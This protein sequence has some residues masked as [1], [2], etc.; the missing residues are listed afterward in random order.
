MSVKVHSVTIDAKGDTWLILQKPKDKSLQPSSRHEV[1]FEVCSSTLSEASTSWKSA[2]ETS[3]A[4]VDGSLHVFTSNL[5]AECVKTV[6][7]ILHGNDKGIIR[8]PSLDQLVGIALVMHHNRVHSPLMLAYGVRR[9]PRILPPAWHAN[10]TT[11]LKTRSQS[12]IPSSPATT[13][14]QRTKLLFTSLIFRHSLAFSTT[15]SEELHFG[16]HQLDPLNLPIA[17]LL[18]RIETHRRD[19][20]QSIL[21]TFDEASEQLEKQLSTTLPEYMTFLQ[22]YLEF[23][24][25]EVY[26]PGLHFDTL[27]TGLWKARKVVELVGQAERLSEEDKEF[28]REVEEGPLFDDVGEIGLDLGDFVGE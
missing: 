2:L 9:I 26:L 23:P 17:P 25:Q 7:N 21:T 27:M 15:L 6:L 16:V 10:P 13:P 19:L 5:N 4:T 1:H 14:A 18:H 12:P 20:I 28:L 3:N 24:S 22:R 8:C 11:H